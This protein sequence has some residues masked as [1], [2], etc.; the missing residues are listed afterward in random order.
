MSL[1]GL[2]TA[3]EKQ[4][5]LGRLQRRPIEWQLKNILKVPESLE[6]VIMMAGGLEMLQGQPLHPLK[7]DAQIFTDASKKGGLLI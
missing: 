1:M 2:L 6:K 3:T 5:C 4:V 7:H